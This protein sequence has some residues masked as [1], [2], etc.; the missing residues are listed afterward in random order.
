MKFLLKL[1][2]GIILFVVCVVALAAGCVFMI[3][4]VVPDIVARQFK[5]MTG[6]RLDIASVDLSLLGG[7]AEIKGLTVR[8]PEDWPE[9]GFI[10]VNRA[11][12]DV[13][14]YSLISGGRKVVDEMVLDLGPLCVVTNDKKQVNAKTLMDKLRKYQSEEEGQSDEQVEREPMEFL[15]HHLVL[16]TDTIR[17]ADYSGSKPR[18]LERHIDMNIELHEVS[19]VQQIA[20]ELM[21]QGGTQMLLM[22]SNVQLN[23]GGDSGD[24]DEDMVPNVV[25]PLKKSVN[26]LLDSLKGKL[27]DR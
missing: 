4:K 27:K 26:S 1:F 14:P 17:V 15:I 16:K 7:S 6:Y 10:T 9:E 25:E 19:N 11:V 18:I 3:E 5:E 20:A 24:A 21:K 23:L 22:L 2:F 8:N 12:F 13:D